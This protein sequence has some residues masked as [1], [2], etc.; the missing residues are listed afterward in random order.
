MISRRD[1]WTLLVLLLGLVLH[2]LPP[3]T[4]ERLLPKTSSDAELPAPAGVLALYDLDKD[5]AVQRTLPQRLKEISGLALTRDHRLLAHNDETGLI[6]ELD[7]ATGAVRSSFVMVKDGAPITADFEGIAVLDDR[8][9][10]ATSDGV[11]YACP[12]G[13][14]GENVQCEEYDTGLGVEYELESLGSAIDDHQLILVSKNPRSR[15]LAGLVC[16]ARRRQVPA[17]R[18][19]S[20]P[21]NRELPDPCR[22]PEELGGGHPHRRGRGRQDAAQTLALAARGDRFRRRRVTADRR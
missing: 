19:R 10:L 17:E 14:D 11:I 5:R 18:R 6:S 12:P 15:E 1:L 22:A 3:V 13:T 8:I 2:F 20:R 9:Y 21:R 16:I 4:S 7:L